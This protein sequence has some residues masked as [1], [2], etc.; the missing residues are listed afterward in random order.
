ML[1]T[2]ADQFVS[3]RDDM[4]MLICNDKPDLILLT[5]VIPKAQRLAI[6]PAQLAIPGFA[7]YA[8]FLPSTQNLGSSGTRGICIYASLSL[9]VSEVTLEQSAVEQLWVK[10][11]LT[12]SDCLLIGCLYRSPSGNTGDS[13]HQLEQLFRKASSMSFSH[14]LIV[15]DLNLPQI[16]WETESSSAPPSH[17]SHSFI[18]TVHDC[19]L[20]QHVHCPTRYRLGE[21]PNVLDLIFSNE[22]GMVSCLEYL[23]GLG[24]SDHVVLRFT[25]VCYAPAE[26]HPTHRVHTDHESL[27]SELKSLNWDQMNSMTLEEAYHTFKTNLLETELK[28]SKSR[29]ITKRKNLY[30]NRA[31]MQLRKRKKDLWRK[32]CQTQDILDHARF[33]RCRNQL[34]K[35]T[36]NLRKEYEIKLVSAIKQNP[37]AFWRY[38]SSRLKTKSRVEDLLDERGTLTSNS[39]AKAEILSRYFSSVF[40]VESNDDPPTVNCDYNGP[41]LDDID[42]A[43]DKVR[44]KLASLRPNSSSGPDNIHPRVLCESPDSLSVPLSILFRK[45]ID[46]GR[47]PADWKVGEVVPIYK[48]GDRQRPASYRPVSL[49]A[50]P[51]KVLESIVRDNLLNH[52]SESG[53]LND[54]QHGFLPKRS[55]TSQLLEV[56]E[57]WSGAI[58][59]GEPVDVAY[60]DFAK[61]FD[62]VPHKRLLGK[63]HAYGIRGRLLDWIAAFLLDRRQ[64]VVIQ[65]SK[66]EW[67]PVTSGIPQGSVLGPT[68]FTLFVNDMPQQVSSCV[69]LFADDTKLYRRVT[70]GSTELQADIDALVKWSKEWLLPFNSTKC[71]VMHLG[72]RNAEHPYLLDGASIQE[73]REER[74]L[75]VVVDDE[76]KFHQ[77]TAAAIAKAS[78]MLAVVRR[79]FANLDEVTLPL[80]FKTVV[81]PFLEYGNTIWGPFGKVD[82]KRLERVQRRA[83]RMVEAVRHLEYP[84]RLH[85]LGMPTLYY[86]R[87]RGDMITVYQ[88]LHGGMAVDPETFLKRNC[89]EQTRGHPWKLRKPRASSLTRRNMF[90]TRVVNDWNSLPASVVSAQSINQFKARLDKHWASLMYDISNQ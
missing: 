77:Q 74:D 80:L 57:D 87:R 33:V 53:L 23:P 45:S 67:A 43:P 27:A 63:L 88:L 1:Y 37:K 82:Q 58:E 72:R 32:Y 20:H 30:M 42:V 52:L 24:S 75:G 90:S 54:A 84:E 25:L 83:T 38:S 22:E 73:V 44:A 70:N 9:K 6:A 5:E 47:L 61:A 69:K 76:L 40:T 65:G 34:R 4:M 85:K 29:K 46:A 19:F 60:L 11:A 26:S 16:D 35:L 31:A 10:L 78:Q 68:L 59:D 7:Q 50:V 8:N 71:R 36:R 17:C 18:D 2:N 55:C 15:G 64:R 41:L 13:V 21:K 48:K 39:Q 89:S 51:S 49:T 79:S 14:L 3:K 86:R 81:R 28:C 62:S 56:M 12:G 66:S